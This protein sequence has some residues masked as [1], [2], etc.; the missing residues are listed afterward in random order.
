[1]LF[2][3]GEYVLVPLQILDIKLIGGYTLVNIY[4]DES[5]TGSNSMDLGKITGDGSGF[6]VGLGLEVFLAEGFSL[7]ADLAYNYA[8]IYGATFAGSQADP[9]TT[10]SNGTVDYSG[11]VAKVA[12]NI[13]LF[14]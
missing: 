13:Y 1:M 4:G 5:T 2:L 6:Q 12:F 10:Q 8:K 14:R 11:L 7:E 3:G 9:G